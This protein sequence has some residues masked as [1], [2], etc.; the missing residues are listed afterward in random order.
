MPQVSGNVYDDKDNGLQGVQISIDGQHSG[1][2]VFKTVLT[3]PNGAYVF[4]EILAGKYS[5]DVPKMLDLDGNGAPEWESA[6]SMPVA[7]V[8]TTKDTVVSPIYY[9]PS[10]VGG[11]V[12][13]VVGTLDEGVTAAE[14]IFSYPTLTQEVGYPPSPLASMF[15]GGDGRAPASSLAKVAE[16]SL[17]TV[18]GWRPKETDAKGFVG[19]LTQAFPLTEVEG[20]VEWT[21]AP[22]TYAVQTDLAGGISG[23]QA[24]LHIRANEALVQS[25]P[26]LDG[27]YPLRLDADPQDAE[28]LKAIVRSHWKELVNELGLAGGPRVSRVDQLFVLLLGP[29]P[30]TSPDK[31]TGE[32]GTLRNEFGFRSTK[33]FVNTL[34]EEQN[35]TNFRILTDYTTGLR[36]TW[37]TN[38]HFFTRQS[39]KAF[40]GTQLVLL[41]R[42]LSVVAESVNEVRFAMNSVFIGPSERQ[43]AEI[44]FKNGSVM[45]VEELLSWVFSYSSEEGPRLIQDGGKFAVQD[46]FV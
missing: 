36:Q 3:D 13:R 46:S 44:V 26:L 42:Q 41:S 24:S 5:I 28:A 43:T 18:L 9:R 21:W 45:F 12:Q 32:I 39:K 25:M 34:E 31:V 11:I 8:I 37:E 20:H 10:S 23:A 19:A 33:D 35:L 17:T 14:N 1:T 40:F 15:G 30:R 16:D 29:N 22:R 2:R 4:K 6:T 27:L 7:V 38:K